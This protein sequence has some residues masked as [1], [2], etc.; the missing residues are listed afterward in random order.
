[1]F[2]NLETFW[3]NQ[4]A[5]GKEVMSQ[6]KGL[7]GSSIE[8]PQIGTT[9]GETYDHIPPTIDV[10]GPGGE[11]APPVETIGVPGLG[12]PIYPSM[13]YNYQPLTYGGLPEEQLWKD[14]TIENWKD[15]GHIGLWTGGMI[16]GPYGAAFDL[17][18][19]IAY[20]H[21]DPNPYTN[22]L[23]KQLLTK[24]R[25]DYSDMRNLALLN[26]ATP[27]FMPRSL[28]LK[29]LPGVG[30]KIDDL[31]GLWL[32]N[33]F[34]APK[35]GDDIL[36]DM[37]RGSSKTLDEWGRTL[38]GRIGKPLVDLF[39]SK[40]QREFS[41]ES[42][43]VLEDILPSNIFNHW[44]K[45]ADEVGPEISIGGKTYTAVTARE[46][47]PE[48][49]EEYSKETI[50]K[51]LLSDKAYKRFVNQFNEGMD[52]QFKDLKRYAKDSP[53]AFTKLFAIASTHQYAGVL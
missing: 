33:K 10:E 51:Q 46:A 34:L 5:V 7:G 8:Y 42:M 44:F 29:W 31:S 13:A 3:K 37:F 50:R 17:A 4:D 49:F 35:V 11:L 43:Q 53:E 45:K 36:R 47:G 39:S 9:R 1:M 20:Q 41:S 27:L 12:K 28:S 2:F 15:L 32:Y 24:D 19:A 6:Y 18:N 48:I 38:S 26:M 16:G 52:L 40:S 22:P 25:T 21:R 23:S 30:N 14:W